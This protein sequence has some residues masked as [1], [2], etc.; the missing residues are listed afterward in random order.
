MSSCRRIISLEEES[1]LFTTFSPSKI[2]KEKNPPPGSKILFFLFLFLPG[3]LPHVFHF[4]LISTIFIHKVSA[5]SNELLQKNHLSWRRVSSTFS[6]ST[7]LKKTKPR[8]LRFFSS[9]FSFSQFQVKNSVSLIMAASIPWFNALPSL[10]NDDV[11]HTWLQCS[12]IRVPVTMAILPW[13][14]QSLYRL[15]LVLSS[16]QCRRYSRAWKRIFSNMQY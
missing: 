2:L 6:P 12:W 14:A 3:S 11:I 9:F 10:A 4:Q 15:Q 7:I 16:V 13:M 1:L 5:A 8:A